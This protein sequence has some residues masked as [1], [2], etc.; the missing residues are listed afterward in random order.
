MTPEEILSVQW[1]PSSITED[2]AVVVPIRTSREPIFRLGLA[3]L[4][5]SKQDLSRNWDAPSAPCSLGFGELPLSFST[6]IE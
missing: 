2:E 3:V 5:K 1:S 6:P 4:M